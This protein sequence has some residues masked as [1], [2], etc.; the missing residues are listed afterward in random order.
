MS[1]GPLVSVARL[2]GNRD[3][4]DHTHYLTRLCYLVVFRNPAWLYDTRGA[5]TAVRE[6]Y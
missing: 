6:T 1:V 5:W 4:E 3:S 2:N